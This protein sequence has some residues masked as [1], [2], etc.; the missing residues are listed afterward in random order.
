MNKNTI[1]IEQIKQRRPYVAPTIEVDF[2][3][4][5]KGYAASEA[6]DLEEI[7]FLT[8]DDG[9]IDDEGGGWFDEGGIVY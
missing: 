8:D 5:E 3:M 1:D 6:R 7:S 4:V 9:N 2:Y